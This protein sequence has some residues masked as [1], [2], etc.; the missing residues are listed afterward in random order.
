M[1]DLSLTDNVI[2]CIATSRENSC[3]LHCVRRGAANG[4]EVAGSSRTPAGVA[5][6]SYGRSAT[7]TTARFR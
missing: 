1:C 7:R 2:V 4:M 3:G 5:G 6:G